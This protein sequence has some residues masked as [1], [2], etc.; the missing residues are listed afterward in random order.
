MQKRLAMATFQI[1]SDFINEIKDLITKGNK[2]SIKSKLKSAHYA[3][4]GEI[5]EAISL[6][7]ATY[8]IK[9]LGSDKT[10]DA[11]AEVD[12]DIREGILEQLSAKEIAKEVLELDTDDATDIILELP[13][14]R[15]EKVMSQIEDDEH[16]SDIRDL[17]KYDENTAGGLMAKE[18][19]KV[20]EDLSVLKC[21]NEMRAQAENVTRV[22]SIYVVDKNN[23]LKGRLSLKDLITANSRAKVKDI[24]IPKV[25]YVTVDQENE[26]VAKIMS[27]YDLEAIP[28]V[29]DKKE[30]L[31]RITI[32]DIVDVIKEEADKDYQLAAGISTDV[33]ADDKIFDLVK[34]RL[35]WLFLGLLGGL[36]SVFILQDFETIMEEPAI[37]NLF[38]YTPL[39]AAMAGNVGVQS[40]A[41]IVQGIANDVVKG[42][43]I[44][45]LLKEIGLSLINGFSLA[46]IIL[47]FGQ[48]INQ[49][50]LV[51]ATI[52]GSMMLVI[53]VAALVG[54]FV[55]IVLNKQGI[56]PAIA[57]GPF[58]TTANDIFGI[59]LF[60]YIAKLI[61]GF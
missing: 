3:D 40:S 31:G 10:A 12:P 47:I 57:T 54:T 43:L 17:L 28:V 42:S 29:N 16:V 7:E 34:A 58:I 52:A 13:A 8:L 30:L 5:I 11:L 4:L 24:Y 39:I 14:D 46:I 21:L 50:F 37:R 49:S 20:N 18:L 38:F 15:Q 22:H 45:R 44:N 26:E 6:E 36:G 23:K 60:F 55:P 1:N 53:V 9:L 27:K 59:F 48:I 25:D 35:P 61:L 19:V 33:E 2:T 41:I 51:S 32:D 56:D